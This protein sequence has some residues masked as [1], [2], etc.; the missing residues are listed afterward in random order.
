MTRRD[1]NDGNR[2]AGEPYAFVEA[3]SERVMIYHENKHV[4]TLSGADATRFLLRAQTANPATAQ[5]LMA[6]ATGNFKRGN[7]RSGKNRRG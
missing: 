2:L 6:R 7:E 1:N 5:Q 4:V 3:G